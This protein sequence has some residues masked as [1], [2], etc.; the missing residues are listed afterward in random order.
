MPDRQYYTVAAKI[1]MQI[2]AEDEQKA[3]EK[4]KGKIESHIKGWD[5]RDVL[6]SI[7]EVRE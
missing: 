3:Q 7:E 1:E 2:K 6:V 5:V 4:A